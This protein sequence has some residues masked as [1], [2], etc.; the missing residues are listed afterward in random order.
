MANFQKGKTDTAL[1]P[2]LLIPQLQKA[3]LAAAAA[4]RC[5]VYR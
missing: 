5:V 1:L 4:S 2:V 3:R